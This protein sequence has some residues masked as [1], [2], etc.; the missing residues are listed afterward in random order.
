MKTTKVCC[1]RFLNSSF[2]SNLFCNVETCNEQR[3]MRNISQVVFTDIVQPYKELRNR[4]F[5]DRLFERQFKIGFCSEDIK[6][7]YEQLL[8]NRCKICDTIPPFRTFSM[9]NDHMRKVH[10]RY[11]CDLCVKHLRVR[12]I[13]YCTHKIKKL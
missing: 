11:F 9:L 7:A 1:V 2:T 12:L 3:V 13:F 10:E 5:T 8:E 6:Q 4:A